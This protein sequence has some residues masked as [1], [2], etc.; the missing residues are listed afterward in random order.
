MRNILNTLHRSKIGKPAACFFLRRCVIYYF[1]LA[2]WKYHFRSRRLIAN[3]VFSASP[4]KKIVYYTT[5][6]VKSWPVQ[7]TC[8]L[9]NM[10]SGVALFIPMLRIRFF[11]IPGPKIPHS[12][13]GAG[14]ES[15]TFGQGMVK[16]RIHTIM[17]SGTFFTLL[18]RC[19]IY[20]IIKLLNK[21]TM[22]VEGPGSV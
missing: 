22:R 17:R 7:S 14:S 19:V 20:Y 13:Y 18:P 8:K 2:C 15:G 5:R 1:C 4:D 3:V 10:C 9:A 11:T 16:N 12:R 21:V 6:E